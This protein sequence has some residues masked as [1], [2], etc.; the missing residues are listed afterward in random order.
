MP[1]PDTITTAQ[2][3]R[4]IGLP[5][6]PVLLDLRTDEDYAADPRLL[7][8]SVRRDFRTVAAWAPACAGRSVAAVCHRGLKISQ[9]TAAWL[10]HNGARAEALEGGFEAWAAGGNP[11]LRPECI[12]L[13]DAQGRTVWVTRPAEDRPRRLPLADPPLRGPER[14][15]PVR[16][17]VRS[18]GRG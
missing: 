2:L 14:R 8:G 9:G 1:S 7:P 13:R 12:P 4:L 3:S 17:A 16:G 10:R 5:D 18:P 11:L 6:A 15:V